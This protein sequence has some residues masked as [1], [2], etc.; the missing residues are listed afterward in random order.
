MRELS[1]AMLDD[2][3]DLLPEA[4]WTAV[5][6]L[7]VALLATTLASLVHRFELLGLL[8]RK[9]DP[10]SERH[11]GE[12]VAAV[13]K[14]HGVKFI[15]TLCG[16]HISPVL[17]AC[18]K[19]GI[20][21]IDT[22]FEGNAAFAADAVSRLS[23]VIGVVCVTAGPGVTNTVTA[24]QNAKMAE[25]PVLL[26]G[27]ASANVLKGR[28]ALQDIDQ[29]SL[30][31]S[32]CKH[33]A[34]VTRVRDIV[35]ALRRAIYVA[36]SGVPGPVFLELPIDALYPFKLVQEG[37][38]PKS[39]AKSL[40]QRFTNWY[41]QNYLNRLFADA[42]TE[43]SLT[44]FVPHFPR[45]TPNDVAEVAN[46]IRRSQKPVFLL[47][48]QVT[49]PPTKAEN[50][51]SALEAMGVP[52]FLGGMA[53]GLLGRNSDIHIRQRRKEALKDADVVVCAGT[54]ADF[55]LSY[56]R[57]FKRS[58]KIVMVNRSR[59]NLKMNADTFFKVAKG[60]HGDPGCFLLSLSQ[61]LTDYSCAGEWVDTLRSRDAEK[62][63]ENRKKSREVPNEH[64]NPL[65]VLYITEEVMSEDSIIVADG[66]DFVGSAAYIL[67][68]RGPLRWLDP[69]P[70][71]TL[72]VGGGFA[73][74]AK[75]CR[76]DSDVWIM[77]GDGALGFSVPELDTFA[78]FKLPVIA[79]VGNDA[80]WTQIAREQVP[81]FKSNVA[82]LLDYRSYET[83]AE[84]FGGR[85]FLLDRSSDDEGIRETLLR[86]QEVSRQ[87]RVPV[88]VNCLIGKTNFREGSISV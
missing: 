54:V 81:M 85:G 58:S 55:R 60:V 20:R 7:V 8:F 48:S 6:G 4:T 75:L 22:R 87:E 9:V 52:C 49:L 45:H 82:C 67:R 28:G 25:S 65:N 26:L 62:E 56:G 18:E 46:L 27:G 76:P 88:L 2:L 70:Y 77:Y 66:G 11:G 83:V 30:C 42:W 61:S 74:G 24:L 63:R 31:K 39:P 44:P 72:G 38:F 13:L 37:L 19:A 73:L 84:G 47:G 35:P 41:L 14:A 64:L 71:G 15:F 5:L 51:R 40:A 69:G 10:S 1:A 33:V 68:P 79:L 50:V 36:Q 32:I 29:L 17:V 80:C 43:Q 53:R 21:V 3:A 59:S 16:G 23:G 78:R 86:A 12:L 57:V 34:T